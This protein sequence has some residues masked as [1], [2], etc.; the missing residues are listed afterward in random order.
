MCFRPSL[1]LAVSNPQK[2]LGTTNKKRK[3]KKKEVE[4]HR[5]PI[6]QMVKTHPPTHDTIE[7]CVI[8]LT[9]KS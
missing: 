1:T 4:N 9:T 8:G 2:E 5:G 3:K 7:T 6:S